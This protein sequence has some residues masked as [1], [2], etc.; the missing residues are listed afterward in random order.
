MGIARNP[1]KTDNITRKEIG[2]ARKDNIGAVNN[3]PINRTE[4][5]IKA[6]VYCSIKAPVRLIIA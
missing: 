2:K 6:I 1:I 4:V 5:S 3:K